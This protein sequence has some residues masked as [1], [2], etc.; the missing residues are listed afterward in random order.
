MGTFVHLNGHSE[1]STDGYARVTELVAAA[2]ANG[3]T[4]LALTDTN[5]SGAL[6]FRA[7][8]HRHGIKP[9]IGLDVRLI[10]GLFDNPLRATFYDLTLLA[11]NRA[12]WNSLIALYNDSRAKEIRNGAYVDYDMLARHAD[13]LI[14]LTG[15]RGGSVDE[16]LD[17]SDIDTARANLAKLEHALGT[18]RVFLEAADPASAQLLTG[19]FTDRHVVATATYRQALE[20]DTAGR[21]AMVCLRTGRHYLAPYS[22]WVISDDEMRGR[23]PKRSAWRDAV[24]MTAAIADAIDADAIPEPVRQVPA[25]TIPAGFTDAGDHLRHLAFR[26]LA[27]RYDEIPLEAI[28]RLNLEL[29][30]ITGAAGAAEYILAAHDLLSWCSTEDILTSS[31]GTSSGSLVLFCLGMTEINPLRY[32]LKFDRFMRA[33]RNELP[34]LD[35]D[36]QHSRRQDIHDYLAARWPGQ[37]AK[38]TSFIRAKA[39]TARRRHGLSEETAERIDGRVQH[40]ATHACAVLIAPAALEGTVPYR[41]DH[42]PGH[43][44]DLPIAAWDAHGLEDQGYLVMNLLFSTALDVISRTADAV[45]A[46][47]EGSVRVATLLPDGD[48]DLYWDSTDAAW[49]LIAS[50]D[51]DGVFQLGTDMAKGAAA[52]ARPRNLT[53]M[54]V[55]IAISGRPHRLGT[56]LAARALRTTRYGRYDN[57]TADEREQIWLDGALGTTHGVLVFQ[58]QIIN[59]LTSV[60][61][62][63]NAQA[64]LAWRTLA[65][66]DPARLPHIREE[67]MAG[68]VR[69]RFDR[70]GDLRSPIFSEA[71][72]ARVFDMLVNDGASAFSAAHAYA[73][74]RVAFQSAWLRAHFPETFQRVL[75]EARPMR[76]RP[77]PA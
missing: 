13:G 69:E 47:P 37:V 7:E 40:P 66:K 59:L 12:G 74:A 56:Y 75:D 8:A 33:G 26:G 2:K 58:E 71:T 73:Y 22:G 67:F 14:A 43:E 24:S 36:I 6:E 54:A 64:D 45:R 28:E 70:A 1:H 3:Q 21:A 76:N 17:R 16:P 60:G 9:I 31:R 61:G 25:A 39:D 10:D 19:V 72:A 77:A 29:E 44:S 62:F 15:G 42:H 11:E 49:D 41:I 34:R 20:T 27:H 57:I 23:G 30:R 46:E 68:A 65:K 5:L 53:D 35:F 52:A 51:T 63:S 50:G 38:A 55:L 48:G 4:A 32:G 18:G